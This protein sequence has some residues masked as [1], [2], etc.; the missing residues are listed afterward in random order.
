MV[1]A[2]TKSRRSALV[3][4]AA[5]VLLYCLLAGGFS[6]ARYASFKSHLH[7][8][9]L[10]SQSFWST[11]QGLFFT[12]SVN[13]EIGRSACYFGN[14][15]TP[16]YFAIAPL[17]WAFPSPVTLLVLQTLLIGL[18]ALPVFFL[19]R[20]HLESQAAGLLFAFLYL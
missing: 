12:N 1:S 7:D 15:F 6:V 19:A 2:A 11:T 16:I 10:I 14:H 13:P 17:Y 5:M 18:G 8:T 4:L 20:R 3:A 9:G